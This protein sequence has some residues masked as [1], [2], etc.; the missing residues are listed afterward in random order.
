MGMTLNCPSVEELLEGIMSLSWEVRLGK[1]GI[2]YLEKRIAVPTLS[3]DL[4]CSWTKFQKGQESSD[5]QV[6]FLF[7]DESLF[8][9][10]EILFL[11][12]VSTIFHTLMYVFITLLKAP[13][14]FVEPPLSPEF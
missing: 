8:Y 7:L 14:I 6:C 2:Y 4:H 11:T 1:D 13:G 3:C 12:N 5:L 9:T 10:N